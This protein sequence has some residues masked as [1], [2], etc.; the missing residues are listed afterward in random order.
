[1]KQFLEAEFIAFLKE[2]DYV[3]PTSILFKEDYYYEFSNFHHL[4]SPLVVDGISYPT[5]EHFYQAQKTI[6]LEE[7]R[8][9]AEAPNPTAAKKM[10][11]KISIREDWEQ[12]KWDVMYQG[13]KY[14]F[15]SDEAL[16][17]L[18]LSTNDRWIVEWTWWG[19]KVWGM[20]SLDSKGNNALGKILMRVRRELRCMDASPLMERFLN[21]ANQPAVD[22]MTNYL[23]WAIRCAADK[24]GFSFQEAKQL[25]KETI[26]C[27]PTPKDTAWFDPEDQTWVI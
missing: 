24:G 13:V 8:K 7:R 3:K 15:E 25:C 12:V 1:M 6:I 21:S 26:D 23:K 17:E 19:D 22:G 20:H 11:R 4:K 18:L 14:K 9:I 27:L 16:K 2:E 10:G 5:V